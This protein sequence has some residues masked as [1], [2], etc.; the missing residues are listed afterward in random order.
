MTARGMAIAAGCALLAAFLVY[1]WGA[2]HMFTPDIAD[3]CGYDE[4]YRMPPEYQYDVRYFPLSR[5][6][7]ATTDLVPAYVNPTVLAL[8]GLAA[9]SGVGS[10]F[11]AHAAR[12]S[13]RGLT[14]R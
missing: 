6:C 2:E 14:G 5:K 3:S 8:L 10:A 4:I 13:A 12:R 7:D 11:A 1:G 9:V